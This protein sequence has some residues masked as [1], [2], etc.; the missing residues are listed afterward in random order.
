M[1]IFARTATILSPVNPLLV[2]KRVG[3]SWYARSN[4]FTRRF[5]MHKNRCGI[6]SNNY[7]NPVQKRPAHNL[8]DE[9]PVFSQ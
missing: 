2:S 6:S 9:S 8:A 1:T 3:S 4:C 7:F 5:R